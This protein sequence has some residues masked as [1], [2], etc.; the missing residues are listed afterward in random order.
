ML[1]R[2]EYKILKSG[3]KGD[4]HKDKM[5]LKDKK[6]IFERLETQNLIKHKN[7]SV[8]NENL[9]AYEFIDEIYILSSKS[10]V[11]ELVKEYRR[12]KASVSIGLLTLF[13]SI[14]A[15]L[16]IDANSFAALFECLVEFINHH[17]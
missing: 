9:N 3:L 4:I 14:L 8:L 1:D 2:A 11:L 5:V 17:V 10:V 13:F 16:K 12:Y 7:K 15:F 6:K